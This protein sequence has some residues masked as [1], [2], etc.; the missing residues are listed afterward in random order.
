MTWPDP[1]LRQFQS[2]RP[3]PAEN[4]FHG[5]Y[6]KLLNYLFPIDSPYTV[7]MTFEITLANQPVFILA[8]KNPEALRFVSSRGEAD[9][10]IRRRISDLCAYC[11]ISRLHAV[12]AVETQLCFYQRDTTD[13]EAEIEPLAISRHPTRVND[14]APE[15]GWDYD[16]LD[17]EGEEKFRSIVEEIKEECAKLL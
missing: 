15:K 13:K 12:R 10:Q 17:A 14:T 8:L 7:V 3:N 1:I 9:D 2:V 5:P 6:N 4:D 16:V 11:P